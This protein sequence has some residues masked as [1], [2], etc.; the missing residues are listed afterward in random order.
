MLRTLRDEHPKPIA[1]RRLGAVGREL[2]KLNGMAYSKAEGTFTTRSAR[3]SLPAEIPFVAEAWA[4]DS[5]GTST[6]VVNVNGT[7]ITA[8]VWITLMQDPACLGLCGCNLSSELDN[9]AV[10]IKVGRHRHFFFVVNI[11]SPCIPITTD[12]KAPDL[13]P[14]QPVLVETMEKAARRVKRNNVGTGTMVFQKRVILKS[15]PNAIV[16]VSGDG[17]HRYSLRQ[18]FYA[19]RPVLKDAFGGKFEP[20]YGT[21]TKVVADYEAERGYDLPGIYRDDRG[22][23]YHPHLREQIPLGTRSVEQYAR[24]E[25]MFN[26]VL[27][28]EKEG[29]FPTLID[30]CWAE[31][32]DCALLTS[33]GY[34]T[35]AVSDL[36]DHLGQSDEDLTVF[37]LHDADGPGTMIYHCLREATRAGSERSIHVINLGLDP[38]EALGMGLPE[39]SVTKKDGKAVPVADYLDDDWRD[40]LQTHRVELNAMSTPKFLAWLDGKMEDYSGKVI[41]PDDVLHAHLEQTVRAT[42]RQ[43]LVERAVRD[44]RVDEET[45]A[46]VAR[47]RPRLDMMDGE[48]VG[49]VAAALAAAPG[50]RWT[51]PIECIAGEVCA[52][53][54]GE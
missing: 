10:P 52:D 34:A 7:P 20:R 24:P 37:C 15:L 1:P 27:Y 38:E 29:F 4:E 12:G 48:L 43:W 14:I 51:T 11:T 18:L 2:P 23:L 16:Q 35:R 3:G 28:C 46:I 22:V 13:R 31:R 5:D 54:M 26:K 50:N 30:A 39:E 45:D 42:A 36:L 47:L 44:A 17:K 49:E 21:F 6:I 33:K 32:H 9:T 19:V 53:F 25:W 8:D 41:P 40:W